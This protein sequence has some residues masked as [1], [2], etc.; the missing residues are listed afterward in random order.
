MKEKREREKRE[1]IKKGKRVKERKGER[2]ANM[3]HGRAKG[4]RRANRGL[5]TWTPKR[6]SGKKR[7]GD[8]GDFFWYLESNLLL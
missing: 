2:K 6:W 8:V 1:G 7:D 5:R 4:R 3:L